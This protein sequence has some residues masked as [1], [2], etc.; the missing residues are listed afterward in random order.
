MS[1]HTKMETMQMPVRIVKNGKQC[2]K[3]SDGIIYDSITTI[4]SKSKDYS[5]LNKWKQKVGEPVAE[6]IMKN[7]A[8]N[9]TIFHK[10]VEQHLKKETSYE[11][12]LMANAH[13]QN[14]RPLLDKI[15]N[16]QGL[17]VALV[18]KEM[19]VAGT[20]D[21]IASYDG[22]ESIVDFKTSRAAKKKEWIED[23]FLQGT[24]YAIAYHELTGI[25]ISQIV[26]LISG[27]DG[28]LNEYIV[29]PSEYITKL[30]TRL[31]MY[32]KMQNTSISA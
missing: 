14:I 18:S 3:D 28:S 19:K 2:Y 26:I 25:L 16:V 21:C 8:N 29:S 12:S 32:E 24:F 31:R 15:N 1:T 4:L 9:G 10:L 27:E 22:I 20:T 23:Y 7:A 6:Y 30:E 17:E 13:L 11:K 5:T